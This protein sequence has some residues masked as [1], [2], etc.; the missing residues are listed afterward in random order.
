MLL[1]N[2]QSIE[3]DNSGYLVNFDDWSE[4]VANEI[5]SREQLELNENHWEVIRF[6]RN[7]YKEFHKS[8]AIRPLVNYLKKELGPEKGNSIYLAT[9]FPG[10]AAKQSTKL[11]GLPKPARCI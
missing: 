2:D 3:T 11:A 7:F 6:V 5:A 8:P 10:G 9:L 4:E 1:I